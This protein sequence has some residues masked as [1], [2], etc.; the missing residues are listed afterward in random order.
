MK[1]AKYS[2]SLK[3]HDIFNERGGAKLAILVVNIFYVL[4]IRHASV[5]LLSLFEYRL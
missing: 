5:M 3:L 2:H 1:F 4:A